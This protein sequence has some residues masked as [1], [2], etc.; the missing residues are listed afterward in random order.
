MTKNLIDVQLNNKINEL[1]GKCFAINRML[2][3]GM[4]LL[5]VRW[6]MIQTE[7]ILHPQVAHAFTGDDFADGL[8]A[9]QAKR[10]NETVYPA[11]PIGDREYN[12]PIDFFIDMLNEFIELQD[13]LYDAYEM[14]KEIGDYSTKDIISGVINTL[15]KYTDIAQTLIDLAENYGS[16]GRGIALMDANIDEYFDD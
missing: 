11:T 3:R 15:V 8:S 10:S 6:K 1:I 9:Y 12:K 5:N 13:M 14:S 16:D 7:K 4:S 2:D